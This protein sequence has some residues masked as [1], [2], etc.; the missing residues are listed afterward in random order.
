M[1]ESSLPPR[2]PAWTTAS[3]DERQEIWSRWLH[4]PTLTERRRSEWPSLTIDSNS[5]RGER[6]RELFHRARELVRKQGIPN[7]VGIGAKVGLVTVQVTRRS[8][9]ALV[10][11][12]GKWFPYNLQ[13]FQRKQ[14]MLSIDYNEADEIEINVFTRGLWEYRLPPIVSGTAPR[15]RSR[16]E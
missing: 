10:P 8:G 14:L 1:R 2:L 4:L 3:D 7:P 11:A 13:V 16:S 12:A 5:V 9:N 6:A 15:D